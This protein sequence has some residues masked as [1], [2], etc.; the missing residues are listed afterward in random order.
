MQAVVQ[1]AELNRAACKPTKRGREC[2]LFDCPIGGV[3]NDENVGCELGMVLLEEL[4]QSERP[5]LLIPLDQHGD[6]HGRTTGE[7]SQGGHVHRKTP[8]VIAYPAA[9]EPALDLGCHEWRCA[10]VSA[11]SF[12]LDVVVGVEAYGRHAFGCRKPAYY[13]RRPTIRT[14]HP[15]VW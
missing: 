10:P 13:R 8:L 12:G 14:D 1:S 7:R 11:V 5:N 2:R 9:V 4:R 15:H 3:G 6:A